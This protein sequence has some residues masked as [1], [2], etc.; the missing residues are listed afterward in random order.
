MSG[1]P[2]AVESGA[3][4]AVETKDNE[5]RT[6]VSRRGVSL[7]GTVVTMLNASCQ[8]NE[9]VILLVCKVHYSLNP[10]P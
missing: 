9:F 4:L 8:R 5:P 7:G 2:L 10:K 1:V 3:P 6:L